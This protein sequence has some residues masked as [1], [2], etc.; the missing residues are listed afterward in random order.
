MRRYFWS[1]NCWR[2]DNEVE[3]RDGAALRLARLT[4]K[5]KLSQD[6][7]CTIT[8]FVRF[9]REG[10]IRV[11]WVFT[12]WKLPQEQF[13]QQ[14]FNSTG[15]VEHVQI[16]VSYPVNLFSH[17][18]V[19]RLLDTRAA[20]DP[21]ASN[22]WW[23]RA[24]IPEEFRS[25]S[26]KLEMFLS[27]RSGAILTKEQMDR[28][29]VVGRGRGTPRENGLEFV[30]GWTPGEQAVA[31]LD[32]LVSLPEEYVPM[33]CPEESPQIQVLVVDHDGAKPLVDEKN[34]LERN[35]RILAPGSY[36]LRVPY[37][38]EK[39]DYQLAWNPPP[40]CLVNKR[41]NTSTYQSLFFKNRGSGVESFWRRFATNLKR[42]HFPRL[43][44]Y[45]FTA[46]MQK[47][48]GTLCS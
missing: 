47:I 39:R 30:T 1:T 9:T 38:H 37:P 17:S 22:R 45:P 36:A 21:L 44:R 33:S 19:S 16:R 23:I 35:L 15:W 13:E 29:Q 24:S 25:K 27:W 26:V 20:Q 11:Y 28:S 40:Q 3:L 31:S 5:L 6:I 2:P 12:N 43:L 42:H 41:M 34:E 18:A 10:D 48:R 7:D 8:K 46:V 32:L 4:R 14:V